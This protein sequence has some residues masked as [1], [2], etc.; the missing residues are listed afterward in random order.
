MLYLINRPTIRLCVLVTLL[1]SLIDLLRIFVH[2]YSKYCKI[3]PQQFI[4]HIAH[5]IC[6]FKAILYIL[7]FSLRIDGVGLGI[8]RLH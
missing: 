8:Y 4:I 3:G 5:G 6:T 2:Y 1:S 7:R